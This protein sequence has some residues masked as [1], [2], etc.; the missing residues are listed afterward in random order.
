MS[1]IKI[2][3]DFCGTVKKE[4]LY[5]I[6]TV[7]WCLVSPA[8]HTWIN[9]P[10]PLGEKVRRTEAGLG[11]YPECILQKLISSFYVDNCLASVQT[12]SE[13]DR[14]NDV[15]TEITAERKFDLR[16]WEHSS[17]SNPI[18]SPTN[19]LGMIWNRHWDTLLL[20]IPDLREL[21][22]EVITKRNILADS[23]KAF[24]HLGSLVQCY[25]YQSFG[26][27]KT[28]SIACTLRF[29]QNVSNATKLKGILGCE[30]FE[31]AEVLVFTSLQSNAF[32][33]ERLLAKM[34]AFKDED[35][36]QRIRTK[37]PDSYEKEDFKFTILL[38]ASD[39]VVKLIQEEQV[40][41]MHAGSSILLARLREQFWIIRAK[42]LVK[43]VLS[44]CVNCKRYKAKHVEVPFA[45]LPRDRITQTKIF[46]VTGVDYASLYLKSKAKVWIV[47]FTCAVYRA[48][49][50]DLVQSLTIN[51]FFQALRRFIA[52]RG[53][54]S[55]PYRE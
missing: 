13:L 40:K 31:R 33:D 50:F 17:P 43:Q 15:A 30:E 49:Q 6:G 37:L 52:R 19:V 11:K 51:T 21:M 29:I 28:Q 2:S 24:D 26:Y 27:K 44:E 12:Q 20:N 35:G 14:F 10:V 18:A 8:A 9:T 1:R 45:P 53:R 47:L 5:I 3:C 48:V 38:P 7:E 55:V 41:S 54:I 36:L 32:Q 42:R 34:Q 22:E 46:E 23:H 4:S 39:V 25:Y 16:G